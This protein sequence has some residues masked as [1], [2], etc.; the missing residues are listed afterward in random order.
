M[1]KHHFVLEYE[2]AST[3][4][5]DKVQVFGSINLSKKKDLIQD[6]LVGLEN[7]RLQYKDYSNMISITYEEHDFVPIVEYIGAKTIEYLQKYKARQLSR[8]GS[9]N[10]LQ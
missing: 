8:N 3:D 6:N 5:M 10:A 4:H 1:K 7:I 2:K 9:A